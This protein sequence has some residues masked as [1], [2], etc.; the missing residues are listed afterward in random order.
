MRA[1]ISRLVLLAALAVSLTG[2]T[3]IVKHKVLARVETVRDI[4]YAQAEGHSLK[5]DLYR[6]REFSGRLPVVIWIHGGAW[7][8]G[9]KDNCPI[10]FL[11]ARGLAVVSL[12]YRLSNVATFPAQI[13]DCKGAVRW[14]RAHADTYHLDPDHIGVL[15]ASAGGHLA[16]LLGTTAGNTELEGTVGGNL[17]YPSHVQAVCAFY[18]PTDLDLLVVDHHARRSATGSVARLLGGPIAEK[19]T[20]AARASPVHYVSPQSAPFFLVH[21]DRDEI[22]PLQQSEV[23]LSALQQAGVESQ[24]EVVPGKGHG[25]TA[26]RAA[27][28]QIVQFLQRHLTA[29]ET[30]ATAANG[31]NGPF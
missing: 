12:D 23:M 13:H 30:S 20:L 19:I 24:L 2:C 15:G 29:G 28:K 21:G 27:A 7:R 22:V 31:G 10:D 18:P 14:L 26:P 11:A 17:E 1:T 5:L 16:A 3:T 6:P 9:S 25:I 8:N 4:E